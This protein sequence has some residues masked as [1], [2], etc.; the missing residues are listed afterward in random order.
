MEFTERTRWIRC[1]VQLD[2]PVGLS[3]PNI[4]FMSVTLDTLKASGWSK[5]LA[6]GN[7]FRMVVTLEVSKLSGW[8]KRPAS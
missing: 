2:I 8:L 3:E 7:M 4:K 1:L 5:L 6:P